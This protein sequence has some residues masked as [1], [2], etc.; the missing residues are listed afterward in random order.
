MLV[1]GFAQHGLGPDVYPFSRVLADTQDLARDDASWDAFFDGGFGWVA[2]EVARGEA[3]ALREL[4]RRLERGDDPATMLGAD[5]PPALL[6]EHLVAGVEDPGYGA[7]MR[8]RRHRS[9]LTDRPRWRSLALDAW[10]TVWLTRA[11]IDILYGRP[12]NALGYWG[13]RVW[14]PFDLVL[15]TLRYGL[16]WVRSRMRR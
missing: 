10:R 12:R 15:R 1:H 4:L 13:W 8:L 9:R 3:E 11:Q 2:G 5:D 14:R 16:E 7:S 6:L